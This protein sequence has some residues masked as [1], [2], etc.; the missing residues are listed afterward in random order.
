MCRWLA[1]Y[2]DPIPIEWVM[3]Q[4]KNSLLD[5]SLIEGN[6]LD[7]LTVLGGIEELQF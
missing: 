1:Y 2:A 3:L 5:Q 4:P 6:R 7:G